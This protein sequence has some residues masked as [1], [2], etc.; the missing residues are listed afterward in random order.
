[1]ETMR[2]SLIFFLLWLGCVSCWFFWSC[3]LWLVLLRRCA[4]SDLFGRIGRCLLWWCFSHC[5]QWH[6]VCVYVSDL[7][8][9]VDCVADLWR[10]RRRTEMWCPMDVFIS[11]SMYGGT[12]RKLYVVSWWD[13][14]WVFRCRKW[15]LCGVCEVNFHR[16]PRIEQRKP[17]TSTWY[18][19][20]RHSDLFWND[21]RCKGIQIVNEYFPE[22]VTVDC[23]RRKGGDEFLV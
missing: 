19:A 15:C 5:L 22:P 18:T 11:R 16:L 13:M 8:R 20:H 17:A 23:R 2:M 3:D 6:D 21:F 10:R 9:S 4:L 7:V 14:R 12:L 1:M